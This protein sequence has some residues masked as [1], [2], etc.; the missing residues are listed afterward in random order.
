VIQLSNTHARISWDHTGMYRRSCRV[1]AYSRNRGSM[2][3]RV[4]CHV[5]VPVWIQGHTVG[6][7]HQ[8]AVVLQTSRIGLSHQ[9]SDGMLAHNWY[10]PGRMNAYP[11]G[12]TEYPRKN[13]SRS[14]NCLFQIPLLTMQSRHNL[15][16]RGFSEVHSRYLTQQDMALCRNNPNSHVT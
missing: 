7:S 9:P 5:F 10:L 8:T 12:G 13:K 15:F 11:S 4:R 2:R 16:L 3:L 14:R 6:Q 1:Y